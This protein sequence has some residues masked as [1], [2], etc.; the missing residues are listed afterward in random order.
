MKQYALDTNTISYL[1]KNN[2]NVATRLQAASAAG[3]RLIIPLMVYYE[4]KRGLLAVNATRKLQDF[5]QFCE[6]IGVGELS[7]DVMDKASHIYA[8]LQNAG[9][10]VDDGD[11][12]IGAFCIAKNYVLVTNNTR[13]FQNMSG[14]QTENWL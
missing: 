10:L 7:F 9:R 4:I 14:I 11:I 6:A 3:H 2:Q 12:I 13:H 1:L 5:E 8:H